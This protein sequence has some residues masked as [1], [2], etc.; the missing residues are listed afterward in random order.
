MSKQA[1]ILRP[2]SLA[3]VVAIGFGTVFALAVG[4]GISI[5]QGLYQER[6]SESLLV[7]ADGTPVIVR[8]TYSGYQM[9]TYHALDGSPASGPKMGENWLQGATLSVPRE[10]PIAL[11]M[12]DNARVKR[13][14]DLQTPPDLWYFID[15]GA[16]DG[17]GYF[18][19]YNSKS[20]LRVGFIG[21]DGFRPDQPPVEQ[22]FPM[23][24]AK[25]AGGSVFSPR[26]M[27]YYYYY[28]YLD[29]GVGDFPAWKVKM[30]SGTQ[31]LEVDLRKGSVTTL[32]ESADLMAVSTLETVSTSKADGDEAPRAHRHQELAV[33]TTDRV[34]IFDPSG[35]QHAA[36]RV[37]EELRDQSITLYEIDAGKALVTF[38]RQL[39][40]H[41]REELSWI[42]ASG[43]VLRRAEVSMPGRG[44]DIDA[45][46]AWIF[47][48][49]VPAPVILAFVAT[50][51]APLG[52]VSSGLT[53]SYSTA[54]SHYLAVFWPVLLVVTLLSAALAW[55]CWRRHG[56][57]GQR[58]SVVWFVFVFLAGLPGLVGYLFHRCWP[59][60]EKCPACGHVVPRDRETCAKCGAAFPP[61]ALKGCEVFAP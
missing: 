17:R 53:S 22:R 43:K 55:Y 39:R 14:S 12:D 31:L 36:F 27:S 2:L 1:G 24:G 38:S 28:S 42:D 6:V 13:F 3:L 61:P 20:R 47:A 50:V 49:I 51:V 44:G 48:L 35:K 52:E 37:P 9:V 8:Y 45:N 46:E 57:Y 15:D 11:P 40:D 60:L 10:V 5:W 59:V 56:R 4:W 7:R 21:R 41:R 32:R 23:D 19:G 34:I 18:V 25:L 33:R 30:I 54:L 58:F 16:R 26:P 29:E